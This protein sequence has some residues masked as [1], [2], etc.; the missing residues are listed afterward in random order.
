MAGTSNEQFWLLYSSLWGAAHLC[1]NEHN[2]PLCGSKFSY[3]Y[4][5][6]G[7]VVSNLDDISCLKCQKIGKRLGLKYSFEET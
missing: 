5:F 6:T 3:Q 7:K 4:A 1:S 2:V